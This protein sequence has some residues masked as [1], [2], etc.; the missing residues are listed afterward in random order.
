MK[1]GVISTT[2]GLRW[3]GNEELWATMA[4]EAFKER[5]EVAGFRLS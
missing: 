5:L 4:E 2:N 3:G 1:I